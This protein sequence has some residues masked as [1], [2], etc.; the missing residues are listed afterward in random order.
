MKYNN[1]LKITAIPERDV[2]CLRKPEK[3]EIC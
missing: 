1:E 2:I 3:S